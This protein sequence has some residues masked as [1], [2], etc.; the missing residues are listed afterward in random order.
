MN[1]YPQ[2][3]SVSPYS[4]AQV[5][6]ARL[7]SRKPSRSSLK[8]EQRLCIEFVDALRRLSAQDKLKC[9]FNHMANEGRRSRINGDQLRSMG[10]IAGAPDYCFHWRD[11]SG[12][13]EMKAGKNNL[14]DSQKDYKLWC[15]AMGVRYHVCRSVEDA[16]EVLTLW[17]AIEP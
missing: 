10:M 7:L 6:I 17:G 4:P 14:Q 16:L 9:V 12:F 13:I 5:A 3:C 2:H 11:G 8:P 1:L 15:E